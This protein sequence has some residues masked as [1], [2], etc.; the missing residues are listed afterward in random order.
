LSYVLLHLWPWVSAG[1][2]WL[3]LPSAVLGALA[4]PL[5]WAWVR[6]I[7]SPAEALLTGLLVA[8]MPLQVDLAQEA[9]MYGLLL[10]LTALSLWLLDRLLV[11]PTSGALL[12]YAAIAACMLYTHYYGAFLIAG[13][14]AAV[15][16]AFR[17][18][19]KGARAALG[20]L[21]VAAVLF[22][23]WLPVLASQAA[24][25]R[26]DYWIESPTLTTLWVTFRD[27]A[28]HTP[29][30][31]PFRIVLRVAYVIQ[32]GLLILGAVVAWRRPRQRVAA[33]LL[34]LPIAMA[35]GMSILVAPIYAV[36]YVSP[37]GLGF[38]L[39]LSRGAFSLTNR[40]ALP[41]VTIALLPPLLSLWFMYFDPGYGRADLRAAAQ[42]ITGM[43]QT[44]EVVL[45]LGDGTALP[46]DYY[47]V[48]QPAQVLTSNTRPDLCDA[49]RRHSGG[50]L[51]TTYAPDDDDARDSAEAGI[52]S[53][54]YAA[55]L[56]TAP[57]LRLL[58][59]SVFRLR[60]TCN[61]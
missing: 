18:H 36:R 21:A 19:Y 53:P 30:D 5:A 29:P 46:F 23:P 1:D 26:G 48:A 15:L 43:R 60:G 7:G 35:L 33:C 52:T 16:L 40:L 28:A 58:G 4:A 34:V 10:L 45:H 44:D 59:V 54:E 31:E 2:F 11:Q 17:S 3:R 39:L 22:V 56:T 57:P 42:A 6:R 38:A 25:I 12:A 24:A 8:A 20:A 37:V 47:R 32:A 49:L 13:E 41:V 9:R 50:W 14:G 61:V 51:V 27:L 55:D